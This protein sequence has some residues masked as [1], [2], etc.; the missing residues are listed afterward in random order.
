MTPPTTALAATAAKLAAAPGA[1]LSTFLTGLAAAD[2]TGAQPVVTVPA[3]VVVTDEHRVALSRLA[4]LVTKLDLPKTRRPLT[5]TEL[6]QAAEV[7]ATVAAISGLVDKLKTDALRPALFNH[8]DTQAEK[9]GIV[10]PSTPRDK[11]G[12]YLISGA[13]PG[14]AREYRS[15]TPSASA[16]ELAKLVAEN[17]IERKDYLRVTK[18]VREIDEVEFLRLIGRKPQLLPVLRRAI[19]YVRSA[20]VS[21]KVK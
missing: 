16:E 7:L 1:T 6:A 12:F 20:S 4:D 2:A 9:D 14:F 5:E 15:G 18:P 3:E 17:M 21:L 13:G 19:K 8:L 11:S 10:G